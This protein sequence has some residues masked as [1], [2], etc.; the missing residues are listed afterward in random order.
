MRKPSEN[1]VYNMSA[2]QMLT[3]VFTESS[4]QKTYFSLQF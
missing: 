3:D 4:Q 1:Y 2:L